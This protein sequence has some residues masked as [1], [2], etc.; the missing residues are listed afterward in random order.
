MKEVSITEFLSKTTGGRPVS[1]N[2]SI[3]RGVPFDCV[4]GQKHLFSGDKQDVMRE[5][6]KMRLVLPCPDTDAINCVHVKGIFK[7]KIIAE[8]GAS[9]VA[10]DEDGDIAA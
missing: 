7:H 4:C 8:F 3:Y 5:L 1:I 9:S 2:V 6:P 10:I